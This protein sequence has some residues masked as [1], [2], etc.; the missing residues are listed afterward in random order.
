MSDEVINSDYIIKNL[1]NK[2]LFIDDHDTFKF[3]IDNFNYNTFIV[4]FG[5]FF[6]NDNDL[7]VNTS[8]NELIAL[9]NFEKNF[10]NHLFRDMLILEKRLNTLVAISAINHFNIKDKCLLKH[11]INEL[12][13]NIFPNVANIKPYTDLD[14]LLNK[15]TKFLD[16]KKYH[17]YHQDIETNE[18]WEQWRNVPLDIMCLS[19]SFATTFNFFIAVNNNVKK[20][21]LKMF[22]IERENI[23]GLFYFLENCINIRNSIS[24]NI[25]VFDATI[26]YQNDELN[27]LYE[28]VLNE[29]I[30]GSEF[31]LPHLV[32]LVSHFSNNNNTLEKTLENLK[33]IKLRE[34]HKKK[35]INLFVI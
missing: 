15:F 8:S 6:E 25:P 20:E 21:V 11:S 33:Q 29:K 24:H 23:Q 34:E 2:G 4:Y 1:E 27:K 3:Y 9:Y 31:R 16:N 5:S 18:V 14:K 22:N 32:K 13:E 19:W 17:R 26:K 28:N 7:Y 30:N 10:S 35:L 12:R